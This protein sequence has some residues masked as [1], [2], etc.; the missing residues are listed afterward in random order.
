MRGWTP[1]G[2]DAP[3][4]HNKRPIAMPQKDLGS[5]LLQRNRM[6]LNDEAWDAVH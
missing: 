3:L 1:I 6:N 5:L 2:Q 4:R